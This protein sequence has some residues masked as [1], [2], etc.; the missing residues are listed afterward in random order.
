V[1]RSTRSAHVLKILFSNIHAKTLKLWK[2]SAMRL[3][4]S[5]TNAAHQFTNRPLMNSVHLHARMHVASCW[6]RVHHRDR[7]QH[8]IPIAL[9]CH[10]RVPYSRDFVH[11]RF[12][13]AGRRSAWIASSCMPASKKPAHHRKSV[14]FSITSLV[15]SS[16]PKYLGSKQGAARFSSSQNMAPIAFLGA[17]FWVDGQKQT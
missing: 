4:A 12:S 13:D 10:C 9:A 3:A 7:H 1:A 15:H 8:T 6:R 16:L 2:H 17:C 14:D 5:R 11:W